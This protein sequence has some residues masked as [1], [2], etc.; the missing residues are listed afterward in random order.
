MLWDYLR[1]CVKE[2]TAVDELDP[3]WQPCGSYRNIDRVATAQLVASTQML[4]LYRGEGLCSVLM[5]C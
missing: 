1:L 4:D 2:L 5:T 3:E